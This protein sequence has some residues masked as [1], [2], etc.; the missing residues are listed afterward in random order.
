MQSP[1]Q[2]RQGTH[3][4]EAKVVGRRVSAMVLAGLATGL[5]VQSSLA[6]PEPPF[7]LDSSPW[8]VQVH[9]S[10]LKNHAEFFFGI[11]GLRNH[12]KE[13]ALLTERDTSIMVAAGEDILSGYTGLAGGKKF[14]LTGPGGAPCFTASCAHILMAGG[15]KYGFE[16][17]GFSEVALLKYRDKKIGE[18]RSCSAVLIGT[19]KQDSYYVLT[20][21]HCVWDQVST[22]PVTALPKENFHVLVPDGAKG[23][24]RNADSCFSGATAGSCGYLT[25]KLETNPEFYSIKN[26]PTAVSGFPVPGKE[27]GGQ[28]ETVVPDVAL[29]RVSFAAGKPERYV[30]LWPSN[31]LPKLPGGLTELTQAGYGL[32]DDQ[33]HSG[34]LAAGYWTGTRPEVDATTRMAR[35]KHSEGVTRACEGDSGGAVYWGTYNG[36]ESA[37]EP[38]RLIGLVSSGVI[39]ESLMQCQ[40]SDHQVIQL[41]STEISAWLCGDR[42]GWIHGC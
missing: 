6:A 33:P 25:G 24:T 29:L 4:R 34:K 41:I 22:G 35:L 16:F 26:V 18:T 21:G 42:E 31:T 36:K 27:H 12:P 17:A 10:P 1:L 14:P 23:A 8:H 19:D 2:L 37:N 3:C 28:R 40:L 5:P 39:A 13:V 20:A 11:D 9:S 7:E 32:N 15:I 30:S 38:R